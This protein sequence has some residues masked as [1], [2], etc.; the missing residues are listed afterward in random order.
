MFESSPILTV[1]LTIAGLFLL[2]IYFLILQIIVKKPRLNGLESIVC[3]ERC[4]RQPKPVIGGYRSNKAAN[5]EI[6]DSHE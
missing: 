3:S 1:L 4:H 5:K 6:H 2:G